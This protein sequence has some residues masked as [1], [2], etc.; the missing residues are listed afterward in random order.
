MDDYPLSHLLAP[1]DLKGVEPGGAFAT[2]TGMR[3]MDTSEGIGID[4]GTEMY[5]VGKVGV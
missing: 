3:E 5:L 4:L 1:N 2:G